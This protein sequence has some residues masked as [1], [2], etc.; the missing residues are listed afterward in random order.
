MQ[1]FD[2]NEFTQDI[3]KV[4]QTALVDEVII[5]NSDGNRYRLLPI[6]ENDQ[7]GKSPLEDIPRIKLNI[8]TKEIVDILRE[9]RTGL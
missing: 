9:C 8:S 6:K 5:N 4:F 2:Y 7:F 1:E 3:P